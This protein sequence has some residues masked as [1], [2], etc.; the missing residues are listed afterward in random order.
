M[1]DCSFCQIIDR[2]ESDLTL[3]H[4]ILFEDDQVLIMLDQDWTVTGHC[5]LIWKEHLTNLSDLSRTQNQ[6]FSDLVWRSERILLSVLNKDKSLI[7]KSGGLVEH[8]HYHLYPLN[9]DIS[10]KQTRQ[11]LDKKVESGL[12]FKQ[13]QNLVGKLTIKFKEINL[14]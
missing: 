12:S 10:W 13:K 9:S 1:K 2:P 5:L 14:D 6:H 8:L 7:L 3:T 4:N 11:I